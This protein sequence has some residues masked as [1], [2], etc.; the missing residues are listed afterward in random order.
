[1]PSPN[2]PFQLSWY[3]TKQFA[4]DS[5]IPISGSVVSVSVVPTTQITGTVANPT[6]TPAIALNLVDTGVNP[7]SYTNANITVGADGRIILAN[8]GVGGAGTVT[9]FS[10][11]PGIGTQ[12]NVSN[13]TTT[14]LLIVSLTN[15]AVTPGSYV[16]ASL[17][18]DAQG[19]ITSAS[20]GAAGGGGNVNA[21]APLDVNQLIIGTGGT[22]VQKQL[23][24]INALVWLGSPT[25]AN[26]RSAVADETGTGSL[27]FAIGPTITLTNATG[28]PINS[29]T[30]NTLTTTRGGTG[31]DNSLFTSQGVFYFN[32][33]GLVFSTT[34][35]GT[36]GQFLKSRG[37]GALSP[38]FGDLDPTGVTPGT[39]TNAN[40]TVGADGRIGLASSGSAGAGTVTS[41]TI[42]PGN[43]FTG[44]VT[45]NTTTPVLH[46]NTSVTGMIKGDGSSISAAVANVDYIP[47]AL[48]TAATGLTMASARLLGRTTAGVGAAQE[49]SIGAGLTLTGGILSATGGGTGTVTAVTITPGNGFT[50]SVA[51]N[52]TTPAISINT[53][54]TGIIK[55]NGS[56]ISAAVAATDYVAPSVYN[57]ANGLTMATARLLGRTTAGTGPAELIS[58]GA[59][60]TLTGGVLDAAG[61]GPFVRIVGDV[62]TGPLWMKQGGTAEAAAFYTDT[63]FSPVATNWYADALHTTVK[64]LE[65]QVQPNGSVLFFTTQFDGSDG[66]DGFTFDCTNPAAKFQVFANTEITGTMLVTGSLNVTGTATFGGAA[67][68]TG[69]VSAA[70]NLTANAV[71]IGQGTKTA[72]TLA[73]LGGAG[74]ILTSAGV[75]GPPSFQD[76][77]DADIRIMMALGSQIK[78][79]TYGMPITTANTAGLGLT[80]GAVRFQAIWLAT[81]ATLTGAYVYIRTQGNYTANNNNK[82]GLY[83][84]SAGT[85]NLAAQTNDDPTI[86]TA[87][88]GTIVKKA[89][90]STYTAAPGLYFLAF[91]YS[92][93]AQVTAPAVGVAITLASATQG[94]VDFTNSGKLFSSL[95]AQTDLPLTTAMSAHVAATSVPWMGVY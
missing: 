28:L 12:V 27:V 37:G 23:T 95:A 90:A 68:P 59:G 72:A 75:S 5:V 74:Q 86:W 15:T 65:I 36:S 83:T 81:A 40:I 55:G 70:A 16:N 18:V 64:S 78:A 34:G 3:R 53:S 22:N 73:S 33:T 48:Y 31:A 60:L 54:V 93:S 80:S 52:T 21:A 67:L 63:P 44:S 11:L 9:R 92:N 29:G 58:I 17:T 46:I 66:A 19:R 1:M 79:Q 61:G 8:N 91:L 47:S 42:A 49:I 57:S 51:T 25:S 24:D 26:L 39:Y 38:V 89:F 43:G 14:P 10:A 84:Y 82:L 85:L 35:A 62:M 13:P 2:D 6:T 71:V 41:V 56:A 87:A 32:P 30:V 50:G 77:H 76:S 7:G 4:L 45:T 94:T 20:N 88:A 69:I